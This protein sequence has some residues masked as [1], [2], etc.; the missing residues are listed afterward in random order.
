MASEIGRF[1]IIPHIV[2]GRLWM[3]DLRRNA[4]RIVSDSWKLCKVAK[5]VTFF[6]FYFRNSF[7][8]KEKFQGQIW[9]SLEAWKQDQCQQNV[10]RKLMNRVM[11]ILIHDL[12]ES[13][14]RYLKKLIIYSLKINELCLHNVYN[15]NLIIPLVHMYNIDSF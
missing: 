14:F 10:I 6:S 1:I 2:I 7:F 5:G 12:E 13:C 9:I 11:A 3:P 15:I 8:F 4:C